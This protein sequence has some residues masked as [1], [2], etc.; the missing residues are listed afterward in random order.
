MSKFSSWLGGGSKNKAAQKQ[1]TAQAAKNAQAAQKAQ[2]AANAQAATGYAAAQYASAQQTIAQQQAQ[3]AIQAQAAS[4]QKAFAASQAALAK[5]LEKRPTKRIPNAR[6]ADVMA[7][8]RR[9]R[10]AG[11]KRR[12]RQSTILTDQLNKTSGSGSKLGG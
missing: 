5:S 10:A 8:G 6:D 11:R 12:G 2:N 1:Q 9:T 7:A 3:A 4:A